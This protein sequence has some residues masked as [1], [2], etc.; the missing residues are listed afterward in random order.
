MLAEGEWD[1]LH[2]SPFSE[3]FVALFLYQYLKQLI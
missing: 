3:M 2:Y 1:F